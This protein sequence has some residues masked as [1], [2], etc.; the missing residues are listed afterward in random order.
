M[1]NHIHSQQQ[2]RPI[3]R[4]IFQHSSY[5]FRNH[6][7]IW[8]HLDICTLK[9]NFALWKYTTT[10][11]VMTPWL[12]A[13]VVWRLII[14]SLLSFC[15]ASLCKINFSLL[16]ARPRKH[17]HCR[18]CGCR[19]CKVR[20]YIWDHLAC[21]GFSTVLALGCA[22]AG[23]D[24]W[25]GIVQSTLLFLPLPQANY[26]LWPVQTPPQAR[27]EQKWRFSA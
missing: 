23:A 22:S 11:T 24:S 8:T 17:L 2:Q 7:P 25:V 18:V 12:L 5:I 16:S 3:L 13:A 6:F 9:G 14:L 10:L 15:C 19:E 27:S 20:N 21:H 26:R 4:N 1:N